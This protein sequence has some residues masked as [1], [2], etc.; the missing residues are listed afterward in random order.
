MDKKHIISVVAITDIFGEGQKCTAVAIEYDVEIDETSLKTSDFV[1]DGR[2][3]TDI[4]TNHTP[5]HG[6]HLFDTQAYP[7]VEKYGKFVILELDSS[8]DAGVTREMIG[9]GP[10]GRSVFHTAS[11]KVYQKGDI[12]TLVGEIYTAVDEVIISDKTKDLLADK[13]EELS[14]DIPGTNKKMNY[15]LFIPEDYNSAEQYPM[16]LFIQDAGACSDETIAPL[17]QG[18]GA[19][20][21]ATEEEQLKHK[22][23]VIAPCYPT[24]CANDYFEVTPE[25]E[26]TVELVK[27]ITRKYSIDEKR[28][29]GTGQSMGCM[30][31]CEI[32]I[33]YPD[34]FGGCLLVAG[35]WNPETISLCKDKNF[36]IIV[37]QGDEKAFPIMG[38]CMESMEEAGGKVTRGT[39]NAKATDEELKVA[40]DELESDGN[41]MYFTWFEG[42]SIIPDGVTESHPGMHHVMTW[43]RAY[44]ITG[45][46]DWLFRQSL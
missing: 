36:W 45:L 37:S 16:V 4:Y 32:N 40:I 28:I 1:V 10:H 27:E 9:H 31:L 38:A 43:A 34:L 30:M 7:I 8:G 12:K 42:E 6:N 35:Q 17:A 26:Y 14:F 46:R 5:V 24:V 41:N 44:F 11:V 2:S 29:Y 20:I 19:V 18:L 21:W 15:Q 23:F 33:R 13:F 39:F 3:I 22:C 25:A